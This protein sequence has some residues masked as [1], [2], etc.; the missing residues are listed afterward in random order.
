MPQHVL[1]IGGGIGGLVVA[2]ALKKNNIPYTLFER[3]SSLAERAQRNF[4]T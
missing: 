3:D 2:Q 1:I 4:V